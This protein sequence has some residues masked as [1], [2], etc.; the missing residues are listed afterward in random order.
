MVLLAG[1]VGLIP[2]HRGCHRRVTLRRCGR[3]G[4]PGHSA[5]Y[6][7]VAGKPSLDGGPEG[8]NISAAACRTARAPG[9]E[10]SW[11]GSGKWGGRWAGQGGGGRGGGGCRRLVRFTR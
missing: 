10:Q 1:C 7:R 6:E 4:K 9:R 2:C 8:G 11:P 5:R 3:R